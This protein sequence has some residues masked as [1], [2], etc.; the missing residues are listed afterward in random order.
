MGGAGHKLSAAEAARDLHATRA[1]RAR[2]A[3]HYPDLIDGAFFWQ[4]LDTD[5]AKLKRV[6]GV[7]R[8][9]VARVAE[10]L[11]ARGF[12]LVH[13]LSKLMQVCSLALLRL[14]PR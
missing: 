7:L 8:A 11:A 13:E 3:A 10:L 14:L 2:G 4:V 6:T 9:R 1:G 12:L 5:R